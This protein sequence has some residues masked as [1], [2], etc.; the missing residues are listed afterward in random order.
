MMYSGAR[1]PIFSADRGHIHH[2]LLDM[3]LTTRR[4]CLMLY[5]TSIALATAAMG[6]ALGRSWPAGLSI[7]MLGGVTFMLVRV[8]APFRRARPSSPESPDRASDL[9]E[10]DLAVEQVLKDVSLS[11]TRHDVRAALESQRMQPFVAEVQLRERDDARPIDE[12]LSQSGLLW[13]ELDVEPRAV[14]TMRVGH[15]VMP[16]DAQVRAQLSRLA[17]ACEVSLKRAQARSRA[18]FGATATRPSETF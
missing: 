12:E 16:I 2:R 5:G 17:E 18:P 11:R 14:L 9:G 7:V 10:L 15:R 6:I 1:R 4:V 13:F 8:Y 3:G